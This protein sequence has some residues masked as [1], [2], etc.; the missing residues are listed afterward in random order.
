MEKYGRDDIT[1]EVLRELLDYDPSTGVLTWKHR[2][3]KWFRTDRSWKIWNTKHAGQR[4]FTRKADANVRYTATVLGHGFSSPRIAWAVHFGEWPKEQMDHINGDPSDNRICNLR[5]VSAVENNRNAARRSDNTS[6]VTGVSWDAVNNRWKVTISVNKRN[7]WVGDF[8]RKSD[9]I[10]ARKAA[11]QEHGY[12][13]NHG[14]SGGEKT[15]RLAESQ[16]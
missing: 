11:E 4:A 14:R 1:P 8:A 6:G 13:E 5:D 15:K 10:E 2:D 3:R 12:H 7:L 9:A 16:K